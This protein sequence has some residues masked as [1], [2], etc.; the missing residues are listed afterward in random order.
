MNEYKIYV[1]VCGIAAVAFFVFLTVSSYFESQV[2]VECAKAG[3]SWLK[4][5]DS[6]ECK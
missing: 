6:H 5:G 1:I 3:K 4:V 2:G